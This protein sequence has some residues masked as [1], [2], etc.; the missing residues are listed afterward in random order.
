MVI[1]VGCEDPFTSIPEQPTKPTGPT[2]TDIEV[3]S[4]EIKQLVRQLEYS[5]NV[6]EDFATMVMRWKKPDGLSVLVA[7]RDRL[8]QAQ[9]NH[10][11]RKISE[12][13]FLGVEM[14]IVKELRHMPQEQI[15]SGPFYDLTNVLKHR[16]ASCIAY[17]Q[18][19][20]ILGNSIH[21]SVRPIEVL[22]L[23]TPGL[24]PTGV[25]HAAGIVVLT[26]DKVTMVDLGSDGFVST[27]FIIQDEFTKVG[28]YWELRDE[29][30]PLG[31]HRRIR[32]LNMNGLIALINNRH[33]L[34]YFNSDHF[35][36][37]LFYYD[38]TIKLDPKDA[39][40]FLGRGMASIH[41]DNIK[42]A[43]KTCGRQLD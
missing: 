15:S 32:I 42:K 7:W 24:L 38:K 5:D 17:S 31:V 10:K 20:Y 2:A 40:P 25:L 21:L 39:C 11:R 1:L 18:L 6:A 12:E 33:G 41:L 27:P 9:K 3:V 28:N 37:A 8:N 22:E 34:S 35:T 16:T 13:Q 30:K 14:S 29:A 23:Q 26:D 43:K 36:K 4:E 19:L